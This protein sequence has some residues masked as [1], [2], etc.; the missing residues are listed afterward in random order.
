MLATVWSVSAVS[1]AIS[2]RAIFPL[3][4]DEVEH[5]GLVVVLDPG[6]VGARLVAG[7]PLAKRHRAAQSTTKSN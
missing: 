4:A 2:G 5:D 3:A 6:Q 1:S 7:A